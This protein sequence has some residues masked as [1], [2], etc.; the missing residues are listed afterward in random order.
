MAL[1][2]TVGPPVIT[3]NNG[4][5]FLVSEFDGSIGNASDQGLYSRDT[6]YISFYQL[7]LNGEPW[8]LLNAGAIAYYAS[9]AYLVNP[10]VAT[11]AGEIAPGSVGMVLSRVIAQGLH[12]DID[13]HNYGSKHVQFN[14]ELLIRSDFADIF[15]VR[16][17]QLIRR[18]HIQTEW[19][20]QELITRYAN[21][22]FRRKLVV[23][24]E[25]LNSEALY[26]NGRIGFV[27]DLQPGASWHACCKHDLVEP[28]R[29]RPAPDKCA[30][31]H[32][33]SEAS[34]NLVLWRQ[35]TAQITTS[36]EDI[37]RLY[38]QSVEDMAALRLQLGDTGRDLL[39]AA[40]VPWFVT[41]FG[42]D[43]L[44]V[45]L[46]SMNV[47]PDFARGALRSLADLQATEVDEYRDAEP[48][49]IPH[50][51]RY[52][53]LAYFKQ[54]PHTPYYGT[55]DA[56][57]LYLITLHEAW[58]WLGDDLLLS[59]YEEVALKCLEWIDQY[60]DRDGDGFQEYQTRSQHG[61][62]NMGWKDS[63]E[64]VV[65]PDGSLVK[66]PKALCELQGYV[67]DAK[68]RTAE[69]AEHLGH[70]ELAGKL[71]NEAADLQQRFEEHFWCDDVGYYAYA[72]DGDKKPVRT[73]AS[74]AGHLLWSGI[75]HPDRGERVMRRLL[76][77]DMWSGWGIRTLSEKNPAYNPFSYQN[78]SV[79][80]HDNGIIA[81]GFKR[82]GFAKEAAMIARD[83]SEA[84][85]YFVFN[86]LPELYAGIRREPGTFPVQY[87]GANVPQA[88]AAG[89]VFHLLRAILG[90]E[91]DAPSKKLYINPTLPH[92][93]P[94]ITVRKLRVGKAT[95]D[96]RFWRE[97][98]TTRHDV[99]ATDGEVSVFDGM[100]AGFDIGV[101][102]PGDQR[103]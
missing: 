64:A 87:L 31:D 95:V 36:N 65:Y 22:D 51:I 46:Q 4:N 89:S 5:T 80:P 102:G 92:W 93:L 66:G 90:L 101:K 81:M 71:R 63:G 55:A 34:E 14:L 83:I 70:T 10:K 38:R 42:R 48:G 19:K 60:G 30:H 94:D 21:R 43:S 86:R 33:K 54:I 32:D 27:V 68:T 78:G 69:A 23:R 88:W 61:Y 3:I 56:T 59:R 74:N 79:W 100:P 103:R 15:E 20:G 99:L 53:E 96:I 44:I 9:R 75:A 35:V 85:S 91:A 73:I 25:C 52:G 72:L 1:E 58:K 40:G 29:L 98:E 45:S 7:Y 67:F 16:A 49:K 41:L 84:A 62:E 47:Y 57:I 24:V 82:Y 8:T 2:V 6:R 18:G 17:K 76:E 12:E 77:P 37:Y 13:I 26:G 97:G 28:E 39:A 50:E 11:E